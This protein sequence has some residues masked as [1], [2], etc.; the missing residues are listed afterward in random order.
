MKLITFTVPCYNSQEYMRKCI[1]S[2][3]IG[4][5][6]VEILIVNDVPEGVTVAGVPAK[7]ISDTHEDF[8]GNRYEFV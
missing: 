4:G 1:D 2:M 6:D 8:I 7:I 3:L 5:E